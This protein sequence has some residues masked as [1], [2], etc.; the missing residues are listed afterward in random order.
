MATYIVEA[1]ERENKTTEDKHLILTQN[2]LQTIEKREVSLEALK[3]KHA[4]DNSNSNIYLYSL[5]TK[6]E[7]SKNKILCPKVSITKKDLENP[8]IKQ[9]E[10]TI[11]TIKLRISKPDYEFAKDVCKWK[12]ILIDLKKDQYF[13]KSC[14]NPTINFNK[15]GFSKKGAIN[16]YNKTGYWVKD[17]YIEINDSTFYFHKPKHM[18]ALL[19]NF[20]TLKTY[21]EKDIQSTIY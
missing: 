9:I 3:E 16:Y 17:K 21:C 5:E 19:N 8:Y 20:S 15:V 7:E 4:K 13:I 12:A 10:D 2:R 1:V 18:A 6:E 14:I 11:Q